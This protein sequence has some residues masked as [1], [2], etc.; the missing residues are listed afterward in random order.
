M[1]CIGSQHARDQCW[2]TNFHQTCI[3]QKVYLPLTNRSFKNKEM[4]P[5]NPNQFEEIRE[6]S[7]EKIIYAAFELFS[8]LGYW[9]TSVS[10]I[11]KEAGI[12]KGLMYNYFTSK[13]HLLKAVIAKI[14]DIIQDI[15][16]VDEYANPEEKMRQ[17]LDKLFRHIEKNGAL[18]R[19]MVK[20]GLQVGHFEFVNKTMTTQYNLMIKKIEENLIDL[21]FV[22]AKSEAI[23]LGATIDGIILQNLLIG[24]DYPLAEIKKD[25]IE[26]YS[27]QKLPS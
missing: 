4:S 3:F 6:K 21:G 5:K 9:S 25:L 22:N 27:N 19:M 16:T 15:F 10:K 14:V 2:M 13:E 11:A 17:F 12:S 18:M 23:F 7:K 8:T 26:R 20:I 1:L 24:E